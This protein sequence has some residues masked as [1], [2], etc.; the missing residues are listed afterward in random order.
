MKGEEKQDKSA[1]C[2]R[3]P[4]VIRIR[5]FWMRRT[6]SG[7]TLR[8]PSQ[9]LFPQSLSLRP[10]ERRLIRPWMSK[11]PAEKRQQENQEPAS[12]FYVHSH[13]FQ[14]SL[15]N[16]ANANVQTKITADAQL[17]SFYEITV[18]KMSSL[19]NGTKKK[20]IYMDEW[21]IEHRCW[22]QFAI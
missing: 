21:D 20:K 1:F 11:R 16:A 7:Y 10:S 12:S 4:K 19:G 15:Q 2:S 9:H 13:L 14:E 22:R 5:L 17:L 8:L 18:D 6:K 3:P